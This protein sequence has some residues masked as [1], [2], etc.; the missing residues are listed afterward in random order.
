MPNMIPPA[1]Q[2]TFM[3]YTGKE[4]SVTSFIPSYPTPQEH[5][6]N[7]T[8]ISAQFINYNENRAGKSWTRQEDE[9]MCEVLS[10]FGKHWRKCS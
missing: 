8:I 1:P 4:P 7:Q 3:P 10:K 2:Q 9:V 6:E 5:L